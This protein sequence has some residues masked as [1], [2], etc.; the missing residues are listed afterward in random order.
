MSLF[1]WHMSTFQLITAPYVWAPFEQ[2][3]HESRMAGVEAGEQSL[4][5][6]F[7]RERKLR[8]KGRLDQPEVVL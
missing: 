2:Q 8:P 1:L 4:L 5:C 6:P 7:C 3:G